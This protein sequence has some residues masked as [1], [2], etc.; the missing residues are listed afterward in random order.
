MQVDL[1][2]RAVL[3]ALGLPLPPLDDAA[4]RW[5]VAHADLARRLD[6]DSPRHRVLDPLLAR[7]T[8]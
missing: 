4:R 6:G 8:R 1:P 7:L 3:D 5:I 2:L